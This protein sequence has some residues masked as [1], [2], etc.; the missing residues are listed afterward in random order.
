MT[1]LFKSEKTFV[2]N[3]VELTRPI[4]IDDVDLSVVTSSDEPDN[5]DYTPSVR[6]G[7][8]I[9]LK[10][11]R[12]DELLAALGVEVNERGRYQ[13]SKRNIQ[14]LT[15]TWQSTSPRHYNAYLSTSLKYQ[16]LKAEDAKIKRYKE[17]L[18]ETKLSY[19]KSEK[20][21]IDSALAEIQ[22][23]I[24]STIAMSNEVTKT[25]LRDVIVEL[26]LRNTENFLNDQ[27][28]AENEAYKE[29]L[30]EIE[31]QMEAL[32]E[33]KRALNDKQYA[34]KRNAVTRSALNSLDEKGKAIVNSFSDETKEQRTEVNLFL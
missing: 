34:L 24:D 14:G 3:L 9:N 20:S 21:L 32:G 7:C 4:T 12:I 30:A 6:A 8:I 18:E 16:G 26:K 28:T 17:K 22:Q 13:S 10:Q 31:K 23:D 33:K 5:L 27:E 11:S 19:K 2:G 29:E 15:D 25:E 1:T